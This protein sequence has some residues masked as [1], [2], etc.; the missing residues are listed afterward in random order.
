M[1]AFFSYIF[2]KG[3]WSIKRVIILFVVLGT[4]DFLVIYLK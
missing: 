3:Q 4:L 1:K 2:P